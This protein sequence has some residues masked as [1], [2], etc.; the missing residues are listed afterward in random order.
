MRQASVCPSVAGG[1]HTW[2]TMLGGRR[3]TWFELCREA[4]LVEVRAAVGRGQDVNA[5]DSYCYTG[6]MM[7]TLNKNHAVLDG[8]LEGQALMSASRID[9]NRRPFI[10]RVRMT[11]S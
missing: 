10:S 1:H 8:F 6:L 3:L 2:V 4:Q 11:M 9:T 7:A 5:A